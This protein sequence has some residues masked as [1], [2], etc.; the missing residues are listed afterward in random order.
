MHPSNKQLKQFTEGQ[1]DAE[2]AENIDKHISECE[3]CEEFC[4]NYK[5][6]LES[7]GIA[8]NEIIPREALDLADKIYRHYSLGKIV[9]LRPLIE[10]RPSSE[11]LMAAD[12][13]KDDITESKNVTTLYSEDPEVVLRIMI[14][15]DQKRKHLQLISEDPDLI[16]RVMIELPDIDR[17]YITDEKGYASIEDQ[18]LI[19]PEKIKWQIKMPDAVFELEPL[20]YDPDKTEYSQE[21]VLETENQDKILIRFEGK[22]E[23]KK[24]S[25]RILELDGSGD[26]GK[27]RAVISQQQS[28][29]EAAIGPD[30]V[31]TYELEDPADTIDIRLFNE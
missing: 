10:D 19:D 31:I 18:D 15:D 29:Q 20:K 30:E 13:Q 6:L 12:G 28:I 27:I 24:I 2:A 5:L 22:T 14:D 1:G 21:T 25:L 26:F 9:D 16:S 8:E 4:Q 17:R 23:G 11:I 3:L 7:L